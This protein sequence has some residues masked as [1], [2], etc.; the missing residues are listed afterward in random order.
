MRKQ[1]SSDDPSEMKERTS[2]ESSDI[3]LDL[4]APPPSDLDVKFWRACQRGDATVLHQLIALEADVN[5]YMFQPRARDPYLKYRAYPTPLMVAC[6][7]G[8]TE[9]VRLLLG[10][11]VE[12]ESTSEPLGYAGLSGNTPLKYAKQRGH[13]KIVQMLMKAGVKESILN[14]S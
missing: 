6:Y 1:M 14:Y 2:S 3:A 7:H 5:V 4:S 13:T 11:G 9:V 10:A 8:H 12:V